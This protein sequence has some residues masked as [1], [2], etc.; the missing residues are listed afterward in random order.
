M[1]KKI[2]LIAIIFT[3][4]FLIPLISSQNYSISTYDFSLHT[5][6]ATS[7]NY[8]VKVHSTTQATSYAQGS[9]YDTIVGLFGRLGRTAAP[10]Y[11]V[12]I[13]QTTTVIA[14]TVYSVNIEV[15]TLSG[16]VEVTSAPKISL[17]DPLKNLIVSN[18]DAT[19]ISTGKYQYN[20][21]TSPVHIASEWQTNISIGING[22]TEKYSANWNLSNGHTEVG[23]NSVNTASSPTINANVTITNEDSFEYEYPY[24]Y[25]I[26]SVSTQQCG[27]AGNIAYASGYKSLSAGES[28]NPILSLNIAQSGNY[29]FKTL[30]YYG[31]QQSGASRSFSASYTPSSATSPSGGGGSSASQPTTI[32]IQKSSTVSE[33]QVAKGVTAQ[34]EKG[35]HLTI[36]FQ[37]S[38]AVSTETHTITLS[39][40]GKNS[41]TIIILSSKPITL[42]LLVGEEKELDINSDGKNDLYF[43]LNK[44]NNGK[45]DVTIKQ[46]SAKGITGETIIHPEHMMD[47][48]VRVL[49]DYKIVKP[50]EKVLVEVTLYN[51][52]TEEIKDAL[53]KYCIKDSNEEIIKCSEET[54]AVY[55]KIQLVKEFL[56]SQDMPDGRYYLQ[57][58]ASYND[59]KASSETS[60][61]VESESEKIWSIEW[62]KLITSISIAILICLIVIIFNLYKKRKIAQINKI[63]PHKLNALKNYAK[64][65][66]EKS[67]ELIRAAINISGKPKEKSKEIIKTIIN[68]SEEPK[69]KPDEKNRLKN[70]VGKKVYTDSGHYM[71]KIKEIVLEQNK[72]YGLNIKLDKKFKFNKNV[73]VKY[74]NVKDVGEVL[75]IDNRILELLEKLLQ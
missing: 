10:S 23:I 61:L 50:G 71:G 25:C 70:M 55:T 33:Q 27:S 17:N 13:N 49:D 5:T 19:F 31:T 37:P 24:V 63:E 56:I 42:Q 1:N 59:E 4:I 3:T 39:D 57:V 15:I 40:I 66:S 6:N 51:L 72:I 28:W 18:V 26:V 21:T 29:W 68:V 46:I 32:D 12:T 58:E 43:K 65:L 64:N 7:G 52:G 48:L 35:E 62:S 75:I 73:M 69:E 22:V 34:F 53:I 16:D 36:N 9:Y 74:L 2:F 47:V 14:G 11:S 67:K 44:I 30:V 54:V 45:A 20:F 41:V 60:F 38:N 8:Q